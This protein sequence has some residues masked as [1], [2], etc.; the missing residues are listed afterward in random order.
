[1]SGALIVVEIE[2]TL[3]SD[4]E[5]TAIPEAVLDDIRFCA[6]RRGRSLWAEILVRLTG[7]RGAVAPP[8]VGRRACP[9]LLSGTRVRPLHPQP[10]A[11]R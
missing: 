11:A 7:T 4:V 8:A 5:V 1:M 6:H 9:P 10:P 3:G 2:G